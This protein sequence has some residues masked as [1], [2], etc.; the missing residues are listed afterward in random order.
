VSNQVG[1]WIRAYNMTR[2]TFSAVVSGFSWMAG[3]VKSI[4]GAMTSALTAPLRV[5]MDFRSMMVG[6]GLAAGLGGAVKKAFDVETAIAQF[7]VL[8]GDMEKARQVYRE[9]KAYADMNSL[10][11]LQ[12]T[13]TAGRLL[14]AFGVNAKDVTKTLSTLGDVAA[15][16]NMPLGEMADLVGRNLVQGRLYQIDL[17][18]LQGRGIP[19]LE[20]LAK[21]YKTTTGAIMEM[22]TEGKISSK[23][24]MD[25]FAMLTAK[26]GKFAGMME[27]FTKTG[28][29]KWAQLVAS[30]QSAVTEFGQG[31]SEMAKDA[32]GGL[33]KRLENLRQ[34][35]AFKEFA[36][37]IV[38]NAYMVKDALSGMLAGDKDVQ[39]AVGGAISAAFRDAA[40]VA[41]D[42]LKT[43]MPAI[44]KMLGI[45]ARA[46]FDLRPVTASE[47]ERA[48]KDLGMKPT[49]T[50]AELKAMPPGSEDELGRKFR[51]RA[52][53]N[54]L[55]M[56]YREQ[57]LDY[58]NPAGSGTPR[59]FPEALANLQK[60]TRA[61]GFYTPPKYFSEPPDA[62]P[63]VPDGKGG[64]RRAFPAAAKPELQRADNWTDRWGDPAPKP[65]AAEAPVVAPVDPAVEKAQ[66][67]AAK[68]ARDAQFDLLSPA[69]KRKVLAREI[70]E[71]E[72]AA[73]GA[74]PGSEAHAEA[75]G[76]LSDLRSQ[77]WGT[78]SPAEQEKALER[79]LAAQGGQYRKL[80]GIAATAARG[81]DAGFVDDAARRYG[82]GSPEHE[83]ALAKQKEAA[84]R[85]VMAADA[86][87]EAAERIAVLRDALGVAREKT[88]PEREAKAKEAAEKVAAAKAQKDAQDKAATEKRV[89]RAVREAE[90]HRGRGG[91]M[92]E[93]AEA[94]S[95]R[96]GWVRG[97]GLKTFA[98]KGTHFEEVETGGAMSGQLRSAFK[99]FRRVKDAPAW[100]TSASLGDIF[101]SRFGQRARQGA[102]PDER[103][104][105]ATE[106]M[107]RL[108]SEEKRRNDKGQRK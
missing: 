102:S 56:A 99:R 74:A 67:K 66:A 47:M 22:T 41:I 26:G 85:Q 35:G 90:A 104:A 14:M 13:L 87:R 15:A 31:L 45:A 25:A 79:A 106:E 34:S 92:S 29:G 43:G 105:K 52:L 69:G 4:A 39:T 73:R 8:T 98:A 95:R 46:A 28:G 65:A 84:E 19:I 38:R 32:I 2:G 1:I 76:R 91:D 36:D 23:D 60:V 50:A 64:F 93:A 48:A 86:L 51:Q 68:A 108:M 3:R 75:R 63:W 33:T 72:A 12:E 59:L 54:R 100:E 24:M 70:K 77:A 5:L 55:R 27:E 18:Q 16:V 37:S 61:K 82:Y 20:M 89:A 9:L 96:M 62:H 21:K 88:A 83:M 71:A 101:A 49:Y 17:R 53:E 42:V 103:T 57:G 107:L 7:K 94:Y 11:D 6:G 80:Q 10:Y 58:D 30:W 97:R 40:S 78:L 44:G 81:A